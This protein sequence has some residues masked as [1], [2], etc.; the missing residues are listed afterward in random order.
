V[1]CCSVELFTRVLHRLGSLNLTSA[2]SESRGIVG[3]FCGAFAWRKAHAIAAL[4]AEISESL[5]EEKL[6]S[7]PVE[8]AFESDK[9]D[10]DS[11]SQ[12]LESL[13]HE[14]VNVAG[15]WLKNGQASVS[16]DPSNMGISRRILT[17]LGWQESRSSSN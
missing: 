11:V 12:T 2:F 7:K 6:F 8:S 15:F 1:R 10:A 9:Q 16:V 14:N 5:P 4:G 13:L 17:P 3:Q